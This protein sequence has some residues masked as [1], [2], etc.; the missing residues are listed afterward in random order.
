MKYKAVILAAGLGSRLGNLTEEIPKAL[1]K[2]DGHPII[3]Y[4]MNAL[5]CNNIDDVIIVVGYKK[6]ILVNYVNQNWNNKLNL[7]FVENTNYATTNS[8]FSLNLAKEFIDSDSCIHMNCDTIFTTKSISMLMNSKEINQIVV[9]KDI[10]LADNMEQVYLDDSNRI[11][12]MNNVYD[13][14]AVG[15]AMGLAK[16]SKGTLN[17]ITER[18]EHYHGNE[19]FNSNFYGIIREC[20]PNIPFYSL[21]TRMNSIVEVNSQVELEIADK[22][23][24]S[25]KLAF[26]LEVK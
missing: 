24:R 3:D 6:D 25:N 1:V 19:L 18:I 20:I 10:Q 7:H 5:I 14:K 2:V 8:A 21:C 15:K 16:I 26:G 12:Y 4:Q 23:I 9:N 13:K 11:T 17:W 22:L